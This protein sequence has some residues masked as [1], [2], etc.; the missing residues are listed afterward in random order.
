MGSFW[1]LSGPFESIGSFCCSFHSKRDH[2]IANSSMQHK[3]II[4]LAVVA[5]R[6]AAFRQN[7]CC[8]YSKVVSSATRHWFV[9]AQKAFASACFSSSLMTTSLTRSRGRGAVNPSTAT[10]SSAASPR[11]PL[12]VSA[13]TDTSASATSR[14]TTQ[15][16]ASRAS[17][18]RTS[19]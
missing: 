16:R 9:S 13:S 17:F 6:D 3:G 8:C 10:A 1:V 2:S 15:S 4:K 12:S 19:S 7:A 14:T 18:I 11:Q 5:R